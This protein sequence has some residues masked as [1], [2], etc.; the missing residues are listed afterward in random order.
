MWNCL[1]LQHFS[2]SQ[3][4]TTW[5]ALE[6]NSTILPIIMSPVYTKQ[7]ANTAIEIYVF[8]TS[9][10]RNTNPP[11]SYATLLKTKGLNDAM[12]WDG[13]EKSHASFKMSLFWSWRCKNNLTGRSFHYCSAIF[14]Q[15]EQLLNEPCAEIVCLSAVSTSVSKFTNWL[16]TSF[17][18]K[19]C[20]TCG[21]HQKVLLSVLDTWLRSV[22]LM[23]TRTLLSL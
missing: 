3:L 6:E 2:A 9:A 18:M 17:L 20:W 12:L 11:R 16:K 22:S 21:W 10:C 5:W 15:I 8:T 1:V 13:G 23:T 19:L 14:K 7:D 4:A